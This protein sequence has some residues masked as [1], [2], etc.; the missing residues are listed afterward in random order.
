MKLSALL[1]VLPEKKVFGDSDPEITG[2]VYDPLRVRPGFLYV[3]INVYTQLDKIEIPDGHPGV[4]AAVQAGAVAVMLQRD[5]PVPPGVVKILVPD[6]RHALALLAAEFYGHP[7]RTLKLIGVTGTNGKTTT[8]HVIESLL[9][10][11]YRVGLIGTLYSKVNGR[12]CPSKDTTPEPPDLEAIFA[13]MVRDRCEYCIMEVSSHAVDF[14][15]VAAQ[16]FEVGVWT[17]LTQDHLDWHKTMENYRNAKL[18]WFGSLGPDKHVAVN[19]DDPNAHYFL[20]QARAR[21][22]LYGLKNR[23][24]V[25]ARD[26]RFGPDGTAFTLVTPRGQID[27]R[28]KLRGEF[29]L[30]N[31]LAGVAAVLPAPLS[32]DEIK[33]GLERDIVVAGRFQ[34]VERGQ[35][36]AVIIDYAH[37]PD[38]LDKVM[39]AA[40]AMRPR[41]LITVFGCGG[42]RD[43]TKRPQ[44]GAIVEAHSDRFIITED[45]PRTEDPKQIMED[46]VAGLKQRGAAHYEIIHDRR[47]AIRRALQQA[48]PGDLVLVAGK[49][50][51]STQTFKDHTIHFNDYEVADEILRELGY[52][53]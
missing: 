37:T 27:V 26:Y 22:V 19:A 33:A 46:I 1:S 35:P 43:R 17:N 23:A 44:M 40:R 41:R 16:E 49:G 30:Y 45:N 31:L 11:R 36:F 7:G 5:V 38:G 25:T 29:N 51:E 39:S 47:E 13:Q 32:L 14:H 4:P 53:G 48:Q 28:A 24:D 2:L 21:K 18:R 8:T 20:A 50:H 34:P 42:D 52:S 6:S 9:M 10:T 3:A 12:V 15:R